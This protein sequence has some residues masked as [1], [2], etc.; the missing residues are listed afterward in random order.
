MR[1]AARWAAFVGDDNVNTGTT[2]PPLVRS[3]VSSMTPGV[4]QSL[5]SAG[6]VMGVD[7][8]ALTWVFG[9]GDLRFHTPLSCS[10]I[11]LKQLDDGLR[12]PLPPLFDRGDHRDSYTCVRGSGEM[13][14]V[15]E[16]GRRTSVSAGQ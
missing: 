12:R 9:V 4:K 14:A 11:R 15:N 6:Q 13:P 16:N 8:V 1:P 3:R 7:R 2:P 10:T 5:T